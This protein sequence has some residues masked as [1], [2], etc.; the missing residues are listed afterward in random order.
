[1]IYT[2]IS[3]IRRYCG[4]GE[5]L[6]KAFDYLATHSLKDMEAGH[7]EIDGKMVYLNVLEYET[8][9]EEEAFF[10]AHGKYADIQMT[11]E[12]EELVGVSEMAGI[13]VKTFDQEADLYEVEGPVENYI[14][15]IPGKALVVLPGDA[16]KLKITKGQPSRVKKA[17]MKVYMG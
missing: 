1:M 12:G 9:A 3:N 11:V 6:D 15:L 17:V 8:I 14:R 10:E 7:Y 2:D 4:M 5:Y 16:H 13:K